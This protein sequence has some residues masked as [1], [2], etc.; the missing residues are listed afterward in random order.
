MESFITFTSK[1]R[2]NFFVYFTSTAHRQT[3]KQVD[4][5]FEISI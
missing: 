2:Q 5:N 1:K 3:D 4:K